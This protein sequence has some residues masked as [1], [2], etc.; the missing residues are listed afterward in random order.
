[1]QP[2]CQERKVSIIN[3]SVGE[4]NAVATGT[5]SHGEVCS[6]PQPPGLVVGVHAAGARQAREQPLTTSRVAVW[7]AVQNLGI[8]VKT[9]NFLGR[10]PSLI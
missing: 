5:S 4:K 1:M 3:Q 8:L 2:R 7:S 6:A 9:A 10:N